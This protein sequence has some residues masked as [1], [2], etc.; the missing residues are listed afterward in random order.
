MPH[1]GNRDDNDVRMIPIGKL[2][3]EK[4]E[5]KGLTAIWLAEQIPCGRANVYKIFNKH[6]IDTEMLRRI[7][8]ILEYDFFRCYSQ[9]LKEERDVSKE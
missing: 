6:S 4:L 1:T 5:E 7:S 2:I 3:Q 8:I 9:Q